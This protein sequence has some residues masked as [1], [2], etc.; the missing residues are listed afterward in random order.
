MNQ[1]QNGVNEALDVAP[2]APAEGDTMAP[3]DDAAFI[4]GS[5][6][7]KDQSTLPTGLP[8]AQS[9]EMENTG[10]TDWGNDYQLVWVDGEQIGAPA[11]I[12]VPATVPGQRVR[13]VVPFTTPEQPGSYK[14][15]WQLHNADGEPF[16]QKVWTEINV[17]AVADFVATSSAV[18][19]DVV[20]NGADEPVGM[21][22]SPIPPSP[23]P[24]KPLS[25][26]D[27]ELY[28]AWR[29]HMQRGFE[30]NQVMFE[31]VL[32]GFMNPYWTTVWMYRV[33]FAV[34]LGAFIVA[35]LLAFQG[36]DVATITFGGLSIAS[37]LTYFFNRPLRALEENLQFITWLGIIYNSYWT[38]LTYV[39]ELDTVQ[40]EL[41]DATNDAIEKISALSDKHAE[42]SEN[43]PM[44]SP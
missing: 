42:R 20:F 24:G 26:A 18:A 11:A 4:K 37:F 12:P 39:T 38:R 15:I 1:N 17:V 10:A 32:A 21:V 8:F 41:E 43:R 9:W 35:A 16:G 3:P 19:R 23:V 25:E 29:E 34:G 30:N 28:T 7:V 13:I 22:R 36:R 33:L 44:L 40:A 27:P 14:S 5:D 31:R 6:L 2:S